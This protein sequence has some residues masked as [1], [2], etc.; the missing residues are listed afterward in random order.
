MKRPRGR[1][2]KAPTTT[3]HTA[4]GRGAPTKFTPITITRILKSVRTGFP[5]MLAARAAG[6]HY[7]TMNDWRKQGEAD[8]AAG[9]HTPYS[10]FSEALLRNEA[11]AAQDLFAEVVK[12]GKLKDARHI[13]WILER[14]FNEFF[15]AADRYNGNPQII[16]VALIQEIRRL[17]PQAKERLALAD[18]LEQGVIEVPPTP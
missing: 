15:G 9:A 17:F 10:D 3:N 13:Q 6:V 8:V 2:P 18:A 14:R 7:D 1:P 4:T 16:L 12:A 5:I 11:A